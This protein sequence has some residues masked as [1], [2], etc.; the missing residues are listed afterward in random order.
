MRGSG[1]ELHSNEPDTTD[2]VGP[3]FR[4]A[5]DV[6]Q[7]QYDDRWGARGTTGRKT[8]RE[9]LPLEDVSRDGRLVPY[10]KWPR[11]AG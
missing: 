3:K 5:V 8:N 1:N 4:R 11:A 2:P 6:V 10:R 9:W 7:T